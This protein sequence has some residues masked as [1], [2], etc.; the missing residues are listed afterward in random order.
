MIGRRSLLAGLT[1][2]GAAAALGGCRPDPAPSPSPT[3]STSP[4]ASP[5]ARTSGTVEFWVDEGHFSADWTAGLEERLQRAK[6]PVDVQTTAQ[7]AATLQERM[8]GP[9]APTLLLD[10]GPDMLGAGQYAKGL[11]DLRG[12]TQQ[13]LP[14]AEGQSLASQLRPE[15]LRAGTTGGRLVRLPWVHVVHGLWYS[16]SLFQAQGWTPPTTWE[17]LI[18]LGDQAQQQ[19]KHL[20]AWGRD[21]A[22]ACLRMVL[23][24][25]I[26][27]GGDEVRLDLD[28]Y[29]PRAW[30]HPA[31]REALEALHTVIKAG[32][33]RPG[34]SQRSWQQ[35]LPEWSKKQS[36]LFAPA[37]SWIIGQADVD[38][39]FEISVVPDPGLDATSALPATALHAG[40][41]LSFMAPAG[42]PGSAHLSE[43]L[44]AAFSREVAADFAQTHQVLMTRTDAQAS[45]PGPALRRQQELL[46]A[47]G[48]HVFHWQFIDQAGANHDH[49][50]LWNAFLSD[51]LGID[52]LLQESQRI[53]DLVAA[54]PRQARHRV[55]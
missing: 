27:Q 2:L 37:G 3:A 52:T 35:V 43:V 45:S 4:S 8:G 32:H 36:V 33:V 1:G 28:G 9:E 55:G 11:T 20:F 39:S 15:A 44:L 54:D 47:A 41:E 48:E 24:S 18:A 12:I 23:A 16:E 14:D 51:Q 7:P 22:T 46:E 29:R 30:Q 42:V 38:D 34:G 19:G 17:D 40:P 53:S 6:V 21:N 49:Q 5:S 13:Q 10:G 31:I 25:A 26:K 50:A